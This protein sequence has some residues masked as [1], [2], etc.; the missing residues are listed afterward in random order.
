MIHP[1][2]GKEETL[3]YLN[4]VKSRVAVIFD[5]AL[6]LLAD[7]YARTSA[8]VIIV[9]SAGESLPFVLKIAYS[10][11]ENSSKIDGRVFRKWSD[12]IR[13][14]RNVEVSSVKK[15]TY[16]TA[17]ISHTGGTTGE[18]KGVYVVGL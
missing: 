2:A 10:L 3:N 8:K 18:P 4:E 13:D 6:I 9:V 1:L 16:E 7:S 5:G 12:F 15:D 17:I 11:K 14:G